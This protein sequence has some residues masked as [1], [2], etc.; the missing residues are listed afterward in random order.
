LLRVTKEDKKK[1]HNLL[2]QIFGEENVIPEWDVAKNSTDAYKRDLYCPRVDFAVGPFN[3]NANVNQNQ[4]LIN[5]MY[6]RY[7]AFIEQLKSKSDKR[8][9]ELTLDQ[10]ISRR[11]KVY[12]SLLPARESALNEN[13][14]CFLV[15]EIENKTS[16]KHR[17]GSLVNASILG[18]VGIIIAW[19]PKVFQSF[20]KILKYLDYA[21]E[22]GKQKRTINN[23]L[24]VEKDDFYEI[25][26]EYIS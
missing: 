19:T 17:L 18:K 10:N 4:R 23:V 11:Q 7:E 1:I 6:Y 2:N 25:C 3:I 21:H 20:I 26:N 24:V 16:R 8:F 22:V 14:R 12:V 5:R 13:P 15:V 9:K